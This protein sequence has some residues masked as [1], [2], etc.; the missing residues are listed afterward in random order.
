LQPCLVYVS[1]A[2]ISND[3]SGLSATNKPHR[4]KGGE[5]ANGKSIWSNANASGVPATSFRSPRCTQH[6]QKHAKHQADLKANEKPCREIQHGD[7]PRECLPTE[8]LPSNED[9]EKA[10][11]LTYRV[12]KATTLSSAG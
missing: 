4:P 11:S 9:R 8:H 6:R 5:S 7:H 1:Q 10:A 12:R 3:L 2:Q